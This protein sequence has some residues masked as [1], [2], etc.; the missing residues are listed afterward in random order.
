MQALDHQI[1]PGRHS[2]RRERPIQPQMGAV[3]LIHQ[4][5]H[6]CVVG[7]FHQG[8]QIAQ[9]A[10][11]GGAG[12]DDQFGIRKAGQ[13]LRQA[14]R[15]DRPGKTP[16]RDRLRLQKRGAQ[17]AKFQRVEHRFMAGAGHQHPAARRGQRP[18]ARQDPSGRTID[19][20]P[21][22]PHAPK[23]CRPLLRGPKNPLGVMQIVKSGD[24]GDVQPGSQG[25]QILRQRLVALVPRHMQGNL[26][27]F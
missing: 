23:R 20:K 3:G 26:A 18:D 16:A 6:S 17:A 11:I 15:V 14:F 8:R 19:Q 1:R 22:F 5:R 7:Q 4:H 27:G 9:E 12:Q 24:L 10:L 25:M 21:A 13:A 2:P